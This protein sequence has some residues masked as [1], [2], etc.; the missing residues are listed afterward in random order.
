MKKI[1]FMA[2]FVLLGCYAIQA[3]DVT[4]FGAKAGL[5]LSTL[6]GDA[7]YSFDPKAGFHLGGVL[8]IPFSDNIMIQPEALIS[9]QG[10]GGFF[11]G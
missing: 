3:Q 6:G 5:N 7:L 9:L 2:S 4:R 11:S 8:E 1:V 10:S